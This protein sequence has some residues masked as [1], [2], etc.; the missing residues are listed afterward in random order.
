MFFIANFDLVKDI[1]CYV[2]LATFKYNTLSYSF[3]IKVS[4]KFKSQSLF[5]PEG[6]LFN[7]KLF[8]SKLG[9]YKQKYTVSHHL[10]RCQYLWFSHSIYSWWQPTSSVKDAPL[11]L[12]LATFNLIR[13]YL[14]PVSQQC[15]CAEKKLSQR[16]LFII[17][18]F[19]TVF[20]FFY[21]CFLFLTFA[22]LM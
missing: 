11:F 21:Y 15:L 19:P 12:V 3:V 6:T 9:M 10:Q 16:G 7:P 13:L 4:S 22:C 8:S 2:K 17:T 14:G 20:F 18:S 5:S 1:F